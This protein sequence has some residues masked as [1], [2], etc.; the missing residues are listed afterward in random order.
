[1]KNQK[2]K[3]YPSSIIFTVYFMNPKITLFCLWYSK[4]IDFSYIKKIENKCKNV[5]Q[6]RQ[7]QKIW[8]NCWNCVSLEFCQFFFDFSFVSIKNLNIF[9]SFENWYFY[10]DIWFL[11]DICLYYNNVQPAKI[12]E[13]LSRRQFVDKS[14]LR[15]W[16]SSIK[17]WNVS[18]WESNC[19]PSS[20]H[21]GIEARLWAHPPPIP[22]LRGV[23]VNAL[24]LLRFCC[25]ESRCQLIHFDQYRG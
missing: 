22:V 10:N 15:G 11:C 6:E 18:P 1:M 16:R 12:I 9:C 13:I 23:G 21:A 2:I 3:F 19:Q 25:R 20:Y 24:K 5:K 17:D 14:P 7:Q 8:R 4:S